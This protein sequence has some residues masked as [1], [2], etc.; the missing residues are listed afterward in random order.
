MTANFF[1]FDNFDQKTKNK[2]WNEPDKFFE[3]FLGNNYQTLEW[4]DVR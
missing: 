3:L 4:M 1:A 2:K